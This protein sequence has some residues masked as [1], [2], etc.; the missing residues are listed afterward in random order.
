MLGHFFAQMSWTCNI[1]ENGL[2][3]KAS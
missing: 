2:G 3:K 1:Y